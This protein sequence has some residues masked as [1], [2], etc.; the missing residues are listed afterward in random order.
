VYKLVIHQLLLKIDVKNCYKSRPKS[1]PKVLP[2]KGKF[3]LKSPLCVP[4]WAQEWGFSENAYNC[5]KW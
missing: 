3:N 5:P 1:R 4:F 2:Q